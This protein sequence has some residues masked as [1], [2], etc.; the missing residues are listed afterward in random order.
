MQSVEAFEG[1]ICMDA[2]ELVFPE[3]WP[4]VLRNFHRA[5]KPQSHL[6]FTVELPDEAELR[7]S[8]QAAAAQ[9]LPV[10]EGELAHEE[11][12]HY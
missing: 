3:D 8:Q 11:G 5:L 1:I 4:L 2:M 12:Y 6:H 7:D 9:G 10:V